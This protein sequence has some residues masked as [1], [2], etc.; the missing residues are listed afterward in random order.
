MRTNVQ[1]FAT[2]LLDHAR[3]STE[4]E[5]MLNYDPEAG[6]LDVWQP[7][8]RQTLERLKLALKYKQKAVCIP[9]SSSY[10]T[11]ATAIFFQLVER[12][13]LLYH[14]QHKTCTCYSL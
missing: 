5:V 2:S 13:R 7:G 12:F 14:R 10:C 11:P 3:T 9:T 6:P 4:L 1:E 8:D